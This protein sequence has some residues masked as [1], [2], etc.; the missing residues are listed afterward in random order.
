MGVWIETTSVRPVPYV[1][2]VTPHVGVWIETRLQESDAIEES[3]SPCGSVDW[4]LQAVSCGL[5][6]IVTPHVGV[7]IETAQP[8]LTQIGH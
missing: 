7:W 3:H 6:K 1:V 2:Q 5:Q 4:N 8:S